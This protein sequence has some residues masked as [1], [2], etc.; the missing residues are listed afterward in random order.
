MEQDNDITRASFNTLVRTYILLYVAAVL[1][2]TVVGIPLMI[3][4]LCGVGQWYSRHYFDKLECALTER[5]LRFRKG[6][7]FQ[8]EKTIPLENIQDLTFIEGPLLKYFNLSVLRIETA[9][10]TPK[11]ANSMSLVGIVDAH[12]FR[13]KVMEQRHHLIESR[14]KNRAASTTPADDKLYDVLVEIRDLLKNKS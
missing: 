1:L 8:V 2:V 4:W 11:Y 7:I 10:H 9:G 14:Q 6:I 3:I 12:A 5:T 13:A